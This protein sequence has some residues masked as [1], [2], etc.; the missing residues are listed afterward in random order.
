MVTRWMT[1]PGVG[2]HT[3]HVLFVWKRE[4][5]FRPVELP[6]CLPPQIL[7]S[8]SLPTLQT[9]S[10]L[11]WVACTCTR[12][13]VFSTA[14]RLWWCTPHSAPATPWACARQQH[15]CSTCTVLLL[16]RSCARSCDCILVIKFKDF[17]HC[18]FDGTHRGPVVQRLRALVP[19]GVWGSRLVSLFFLPLSGSGAEP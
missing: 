12:G 16:D 4:V 15:G 1:G 17:H 8:G 18:L 7:L 13:C 19:E 14:C 9:W 10:P 5:K 11:A 3:I 6:A 2:V